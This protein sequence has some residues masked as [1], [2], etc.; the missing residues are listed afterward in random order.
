MTPMAPPPPFRLVEPQTRVSPY[1]AVFVL[2]APA[3]APDAAEPLIMIVGSRTSSR[4]NARRIRTLANEEHP[5]DR[6][7]IARLRSPT[8]RTASW[9]PV[10]DIAIERATALLD[11]AFA[12]VD[13]W[14]RPGVAS[15]PEGEML[16]EWY[17]GGRRLTVTVSAD[18]A[19]YL[20][21]W[22]KGPDIEFEDGTLSDDSERL[23]ALVEW[24]R[25]G[26][27]AK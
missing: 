9:R 1:R 17:R 19:E 3:R 16:V 20:R 11:G 14:S 2:S 12:L 18:G 25:D 21:S 8:G 10:S 23:A 7:T 26:W 13:P 15:T 6:T 24:V 5:L 22:A 27:S 4:S